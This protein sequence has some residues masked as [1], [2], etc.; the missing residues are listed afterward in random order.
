MRRA[1][2]DERNHEQQRRSVGLGQ[3]EPNDGPERDEKA[4]PVTA[5]RAEPKHRRPR[6][7]HELPILVQMPFDKVRNGQWG[8]V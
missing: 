4:V 7:R 2:H 1:L 6:T 5:E 8:I 3:R